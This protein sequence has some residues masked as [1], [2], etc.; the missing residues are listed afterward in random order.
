MNKSILI[1]GGC[2]MIGK[3]LIKYLLNDS[4]VEKIT[5][6]DNFISSNKQEF[7]KFIEK[8]NTKNIV[9]LHEF[10][11]CDTKNMEFVKLNFPFDEIYHLASLASPVFYKKFPIE[12]L[13]TGYQGT[14]NI[15][16]IVRYQSSKGLGSTQNRKIKVLFSSTSEVYGDPKISPQHENYYGYVNSF[17]ERSSYDESKRIAETLCYTYINHFKLDVKIA[18]IFNTYGPEMMLNDGRIITECIRNLMNDTTL[19]IYGDGNQTRSIT[20]VLNTVNMLVKLMASDSNTP[21]NIGNNEELTINEI[22]NITEKVYQDYVEIFGCEYSLNKD[23]KIKLKKEYVPL[24]QNDPLKRCPCLERNKKILG[25]EKY[26]SIRDGIF[27]T[28]EYF[29]DN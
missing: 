28:I 5:V 7:E 14:K 19:K 17:G 27:S 26:I 24:T 22:V 13:N 15:L 3:N 8:Y 20:Y 2:G 1:T 23:T 9:I 6:F 16:E 12:T 29:F 10:D 18:R 25:E 21:V 11:I 4:K